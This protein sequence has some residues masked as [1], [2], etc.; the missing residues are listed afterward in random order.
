MDW[1]HYKAELPHLDVDAIRADYE[2]HMGRIPAITYDENQ[3]IQEHAMQEAEFDEIAHYAKMRAGELRELQAESEEHKL[4]ENYTVAR[5]MQR[6]DGLFEQ[7]WSEFQKLNLDRSVRP[8]T[9]VPDH[10]TPEERT[11]LRE[12]I[13]ERLN[14]DVDDIPN[15]AAEE[16]RA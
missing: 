15:A 2:A 13:A 11:S 14:V 16:E 1:D 3:D 4:D 9:D 7:E 12:S 6:F 5:A 10:I 8:L